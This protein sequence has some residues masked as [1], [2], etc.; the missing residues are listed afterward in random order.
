MKPCLATLLQMKPWGKLG[1]EYYSWLMEDTLWL[2][3]RIIK[4]N[5]DVDWD[6]KHW[7]TLSE[8]LVYAN[9]GAW[10]ENECSNLILA[11]PVSLGVDKQFARPHKFKVRKTVVF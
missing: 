7:M 9:S 8:Q 10:A 5:I 6:D 1:R 2:E 11:E 4:Y 3:Q